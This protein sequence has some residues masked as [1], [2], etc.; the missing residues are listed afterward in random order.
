V[1]LYLDEVVF[2]PAPRQPARRFAVLISRPVFL[3]GLP[4]VGGH[5]WGNTAHATTMAPKR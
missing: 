1:G 2:G 4:L 3:Y 5:H